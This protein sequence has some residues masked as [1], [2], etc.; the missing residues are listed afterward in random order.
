MRF[1]PPL[2]DLST[3]IVNNYFRWTGRH[4]LDPS[5]EGTPLADALFHLDAVVVSHDTQ[6]DPV[7][8]YGNQLA[9][10]LFEMDWD[11]FTR[12]PSRF[13]AEPMNQP[14]REALLTAVSQTGFTDTYSGVRISRTGKRFRIQQA[15]VWQLLTPDGTPCGQAATFRHWTPLPTP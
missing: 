3:L 5:L 12:L 6:P 4:L 14:E 9:L 11:T 15:T 8:Q 2:V 1:P 7:F 13:S 10:S